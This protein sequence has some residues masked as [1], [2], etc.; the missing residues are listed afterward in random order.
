M[1]SFVFALFLIGGAIIVFLF[2]PGLKMSKPVSR[3]GGPAVLILG[4]IILIGSMVKVI[5]AGE[6]GVVVIFGQPQKK[7]LYSGINLVL[8]Y[9]NVYKYSTRIIEL[10]EEGTNAVEAR[11]GNGLIVHLDSTTLYRIDSTKIVEIYTNISTSLAELQDKILLTALRSVIRDIASR[12]STEDIYSTKRDVLQLDI[13]KALQ[14][15]VGSKGII[16]DRFN[17][18]KISLPEEVD[19]SIQLKIS[20]QQEAEAMQ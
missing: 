14:E 8:P 17:I 7:A 4:V 15:M 13:E 16:I 2:G 9:A 20:A 10:T 6:V 3:I 5:D 11:A 19:K 18:R 1:G 12:Y